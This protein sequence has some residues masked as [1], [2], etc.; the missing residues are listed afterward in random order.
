MTLNGEPP[1]SLSAPAAPETSPLN[2]SVTTDVALVGAGFSGLISAL[3]LLRRGL[4]VV[5]IE[6]GEIGQGGSGR[7]HGQCIPVFRYLD[8]DRLPAAGFK[9]LRDSGRLV[10]EQI[11]AL[12]ID[13]E[14]VQ[15]G[16]IS[17]AHNRLGV[18]RARAQYAIYRSFGKTGS[19][20]GP[21]EV[22]ELTGTQAYV[23]GWVHNEGGHLNP[24]A[25]GRGLARAALGAG[26]GVYTE[27]P[28]TGLAREA[29]HWHIR[30]PRGE[31]KARTV[32][33]TVNAYGTAAIPP[34]LLHS[35]VPIQAYAV[36]SAPLPTDLRRLV[37]PGGMNFG[38]TR[39]DPMF[40]RVDASGRI[41]TGGLVELRRGRHLAATVRALSRRVGS[42]YPMLRELD[43]EHHW[44]GTLGVTPDQRP[45][46]VNLDDGLWGLTGYSGRGVPTSAA[47]GRAFAATLVDRKEGA[48]LWPAERL[49]AIA[50]G[51]ALGWIVQ[52][53]R[54][55]LNRLRDRLF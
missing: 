13:C 29:G 48:S 11:S 36:A 51:R 26:A 34:R 30:T 46:I 21:E 7:N 9:L 43:W 27:T 20:L 44:T 8:P 24:L 37:L 22:A 15:N 53:G 40:F 32:G 52:S 12:R 5:L 47:L 6:A 41:I 10:F 42:L 55:P 31:I 45:A 35:I 14:A 17:A 18:E 39:R 4:G 33:L 19:F 28:L 2:G 38:D 3:E 49:S 16:S 50:A 54:G 23:G 25:Y 1:Y